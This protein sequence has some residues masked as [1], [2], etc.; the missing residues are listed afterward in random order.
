MI[1]AS[2]LAAFV[3]AMAALRGSAR[4]EDIP[5]TAL[6]RV[7]SFY[8]LAGAVG[9]AVFGLLRPHRERYAGKY[10][11]AYLILFLVY[12]GGA[13]AFYPLMAESKSS[14]IRLADMIGIWAV[15]CLVPAPIYIKI[16]K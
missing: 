15:L 12:G 1:Y 3:V 5:A 10:L 9:G 11:T 6:W 16:T 2:L 8:Y 14:P 13:A 7:V 4:F